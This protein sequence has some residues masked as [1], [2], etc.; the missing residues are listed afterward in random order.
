MNLTVFFVTEIELSPLKSK[1]LDTGQA[2]RIPSSAGCKRDLI[3]DCDSSGLSHCRSFLGLNI[4]GILFLELC[5]FES[6]ELAFVV[7]IEKVRVDSLLLF[8]KETSPA[9]AKMD[10]SVIEIKYGVLLFSSV[11]HSKKPLAGIRHLPV[12]MEFLY[13][14]LSNI[15][16]H[17]AFT[18]LFLICL[19][20]D[21]SFVQ[22][23]TRPH[24]AG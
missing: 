18:V 15:V 7:I 24:S 1:G 13:E 16:S 12:F 8:H 14:G 3:S 9:I 20:P 4:T 23:G 2:D 11:F 17:L 21:I 22:V 5:I 6:S 10:L 19:A